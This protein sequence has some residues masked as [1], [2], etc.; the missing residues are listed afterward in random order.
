MRRAAKVSC[1]VKWADSVSMK[2]R[3]FFQC[4]CLGRFEQVLLTGY[5]AVSLVLIL[6]LLWFVLYGDSLI[7]LIYEQRSLPVLN[8][9]IQHQPQFSI[10]H[11]LGI[12]KDIALH[13]LVCGFSLSAVAVS[14]L[15]I[16]YRFF[17]SERKLPIVWIIFTCCFVA[18][19]LFL[20]N[21]EL[22]ITSIHTF[23][24]AGP[25]YQIINGNTPPMDPLFGGEILHYQWGHPWAAAM[26][27]KM[28]NVTPFSSFA[29]IN[30]LSLAVCLWLLYKISNRLIDNPK[31]N[32]FSSFFT[33]YCGVFVRPE[34]LLKLQEVIP[35]Y[36]GENRVFPLLI[37]FHNNN[38]VPLGFAFF[39]LMVYGVLKLFENRRTVLYSSLILVGAA[40]SLFFYTAFGPS[41]FAWIGCMGLFW[42]MKYK[43]HDFRVFGKNLLILAFLSVVSA[44]IAC[45][46]L[47]QISSSGGYVHAEFFNPYFMV[48]NLLNFILPT[49]LSLLLVFVCRKYLAQNLERQNRSL[50]LCLFLSSM[51]C[52]LF[53]HFP[54]GVEYKFMLLALVPFGI[55]G[56]IAL[57]RIHS[58]FR[59]LG[60]GIFLLML[61][62]AAQFCRYQFESSPQ[63]ILDVNYAA[64]YY[65]SGTT[66]ECRDAEENAMYRWIRENTPENAYF[67]DMQTK[68]PVYAQRCLWVGFETGSILPGYG[69]RMLRIKSLHGYDDQEYCQRQEIA[70][71]IFGCR[72]SLTEDEIAAYLTNNQI[73]VV[74]RS[75]VFDISA[76][77]PSLH[78]VFKS[79]TGRFRIVVPASWHS[80]LPIS[81]AR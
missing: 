29:I 22:K 5:T 66:L 30:V 80:N 79:E 20:Y 61:A 16:L 38:G 48:Q 69:M 18:G 15:M 11:Y 25:A 50:L 62:P 71:H 36:G 45:P 59:W 81:T 33:I 56:G 67:L 65:E 49:S 78:E 17:F 35:F 34:T 24:Y 31:I 19:S 7:R 76:N 70:Q 32:A 52:Y 21:T 2:N 8:Q 57:A 37:K 4:G 58:R 1:V 3:V 53:F 44:A 12:K 40:G 43:E 23:F 68:I 60:L 41:I 26:L 74:I 54:S 14:A 27:S 64:P 47:R 9:L 77:H 73:A 46:Y 51:A 28:L 75:E 42:L 39:L 6:S 63:S 72:Q 55:T 10:D 13:V